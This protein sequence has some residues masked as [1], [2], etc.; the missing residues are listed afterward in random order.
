LNGKLEA[1]NNYLKTVT[2]GEMSESKL[3]E[4]AYLRALARFP[5][6]RERGKLAAGLSSGAEGE[7]RAAI[8]DLYWSILSTKEFLFNH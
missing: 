5:S 7:K 6:D 8:E 3:V 1:K 4:D 2:E